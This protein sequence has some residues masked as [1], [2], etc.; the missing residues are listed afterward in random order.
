MKEETKMGKA[1]VTRGQI[2]ISKDHPSMSVEVLR[3]RGG[4]VTYA[5]PGFDG[6]ATSAHESVFL[7]WYR[8]ADPGCG[9]V[10]ACDEYAGLERCG[11]PAGALCSACLARKAV[12]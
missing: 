12:K 8:P 9:I 1:T 5:E 11:D 6:P 3:S 7:S 10:V 4:H 2:W